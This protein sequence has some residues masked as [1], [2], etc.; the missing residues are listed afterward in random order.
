MMVTE[1]ELL[2]YTVRVAGYLFLGRSLNKD[3]SGSLYRPYHIL[4]S[5]R[6]RHVECGNHGPVKAFHRGEMFLPFTLACWMV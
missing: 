1:R 3:Y 2:T 4:N 6:S 5:L